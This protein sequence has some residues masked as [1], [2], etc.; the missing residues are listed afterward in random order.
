MPVRVNKE[1]DYLKIYKLLVTE[2]SIDDNATILVANSRMVGS[3]M[4]STK[5]NSNNF[6]ILLISSK[7]QYL[8]KLS[9][10]DRRELMV[11]KEKVLEIAESLIETG[12]IYIATGDR[13]NRNIGLT[14]LLAANE[15]GVLSINKDEE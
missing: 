9:S 6:N 10:Q 3:A 15:Q 12:E 8:F 7:N 4:L 13:A 5:G 14:L 1:E 2:Y 11:F